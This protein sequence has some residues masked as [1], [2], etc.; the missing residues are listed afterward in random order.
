M[1]ENDLITNENIVEKK[2][3]NIFIN[4]LIVF[5]ILIISVVMYAKYIGTSGL[6]IREYRIKSELIPSNFSGVKVV[7]FSDILYGSTVSLDDVQ[8]IVDEINIRK[9][10]IVLFGGGLL[11]NDFKLKNKDKEK[12]VELFGSID[13]KLGKY[14][15]SGYTDDAKVL[16]ILNQ[17]GFIVLNNSHELIYNEEETPICLFGVGSYNLG[18]YDLTKALEYLNSNP[19]CYSVLFTHEADIVSNILVLEHKPNVI[20]AGNSLGGEIKVP[21]YGPLKRYEGNKKYYLDYYEEDN[22]HIYISSGIGT[23]D[24][25]MRLF[26]KPSIN[27]F[28]LKS[29]TK[30]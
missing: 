20:L 21:F 17:S 4:I 7:Y 16:E 5:V 15:V 8:N 6:V 11:S 26:N 30:K 19:N 10:D 29:D 18:E 25:N 23:K 28:R 3:S 14:A 12:F 22:I 27:F 9:P 24:Y 13:A 1:E 2:K